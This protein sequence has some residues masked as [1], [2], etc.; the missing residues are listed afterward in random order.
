MMRLSYLNRWYGKLI[1]YILITGSLSGCPLTV[2]L[3]LTTEKPLIVKVIMD[4]P[5]EVKLDEINANAN[6]GLN[7]LPPI[8]V[9]ANV[10]VTQLPPIRMGLASRKSAESKK[11]PKPA[12]KETPVTTKEPTEKKT[13][14]S[15]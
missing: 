1:F 9:K 5:V 6:I 14:P 8:Q 2:N 11:E 12:L 4:K 7:K 3:N 10:G 15:Q 13:E